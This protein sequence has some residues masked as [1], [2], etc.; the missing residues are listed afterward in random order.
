MRERRQ[1]TE[2]AVD[3]S[4]VSWNDLQLFSSELDTQILAIVLQLPTLQ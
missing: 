3:K 4:G 1:M 2:V